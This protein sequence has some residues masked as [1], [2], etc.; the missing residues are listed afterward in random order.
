MVT[1]LYNFLEGICLIFCF[2]FNDIF[3]KGFDSTQIPFLPPRGRKDYQ[4]NRDIDKSDD[5]YDLF[6]PNRGKKVYNPHINIEKRTNF[7]DIFDVQDLFVPNRGKKKL[8]K[9]NN[10]NNNLNLPKRY[11]ILDDLKGDLF[12]PNRGKKKQPITSKMTTQS[13][14]NFIKNEKLKALSSKKTNK[15]LSNIK[16]WPTFDDLDLGDLFYPNRGK[17]SISAKDFYQ[18]FTTQNDN[19]NNLNKIYGINTDNDGRLHRMDKQKTSIN[20]D[21]PIVTEETFNKQLIDN[22]QINDE[23]QQQQQQLVNDY[24]YYYYY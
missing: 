5:R 2:L 22:Q 15:I 24:Y 12:I 7:N 10:D 8:T 18:D 21:E 3:E 1:F 17:R 20:N 11:T 4:D 9:Q 6:M 13:Y 14:I 16:K 19:K 23:E